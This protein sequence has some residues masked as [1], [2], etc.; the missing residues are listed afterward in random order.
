MMESD[1]PARTF[2]GQGNLKRVS[3]ALKAGGID[4]WP[5]VCSWLNISPGSPDYF[6]KDAKYGLS[7]TA[8]HYEFET[9]PRY[10]SH[11]KV[12]VVENPY[13]TALQV[14][15]Q[16]ADSEFLVPGPWVQLDAEDAL[17]VLVL[18]VPSE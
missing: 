18:G 1:D 15:H 5:R 7:P 17:K 16:T 6:V 2:W 12:V 9:R 14:L 13:S 4:N 8:D 3:E 11:R 10:D